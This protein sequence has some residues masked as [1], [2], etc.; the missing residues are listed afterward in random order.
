MLICVSKIQITY[1][2]RQRLKFWAF[3]WDMITFQKWRN[4]LT[5][6]IH[7]R[8]HGIPLW[9]V[10]PACSMNYEFFCLCI[11]V[12][13][14]EF[15]KYILL[16]ITSNNM[17]QHFG[18]T[19]LII[20]HLHVDNSQKNHVQNRMWGL[21]LTYT[22]CSDELQYKHTKMHTYIN[23]TISDVSRFRICTPV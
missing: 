12:F 10:D 16:T 4:E 14:A 15:F 5:V 13:F 17:L 9:T 1:K 19:V 21:S 22:G 7:I 23:T 11:L 2:T 6:H 8:R 18:K 20:I 3:I